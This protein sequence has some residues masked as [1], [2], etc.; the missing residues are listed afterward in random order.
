MIE[1]KC[2]VGKGTIE[3]GFIVS[4]CRSSQGSVKGSLCL[5]GGVAPG[6]L[7]FLLFFG[8]IALF[9]FLHGVLDSG[10]FLTSLSS[11]AFLSRGSL[12]GNFLLLVIELSVHEEVNH[13]IP[14]SV[15]G[16]LTS[17]IEDFSAE[18]PEH[19]SD[20]LAALV[21]CGDGNIDEVKGRVGVSKGNGGNVHVRALNQGLVVGAGV[22]HDDEAGLEEPSY[23]IRFDITSWCSG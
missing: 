3:D 10:T 9:E 19:E 12:S 4:N 1:L 5:G 22:A 23:L 15:S 21:V 20:A 14:I 6:L 7:F 2:F 13:D 18:E 17:E 16:D 11:L 8:A